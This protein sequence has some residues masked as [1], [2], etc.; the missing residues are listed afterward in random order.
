MSNNWFMESFEWKFK[1]DT[2][3]IMLKQIIH[4]KKKRRRLSMNQCLLTPSWSNLYIYYWSFF[5]LFSSFISV[6]YFGSIL[7][8]HKKANCFSYQNKIFI[9]HR[10]MTCQKILILPYDFF[11][12][13]RKICFLFIYIGLL[14]IWRFLSSI[15]R[16]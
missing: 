5:V 9:E 14:I 3:V 16:A 12:V 6:Y 13:T 15:Y 8:L 1:I 7:L 4:I 2:N 10:L 11:Y